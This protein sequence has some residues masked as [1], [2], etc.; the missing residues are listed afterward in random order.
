MHQ[1]L[2]SQSFK[3]HRRPTLEARHHPLETV[4]QERRKSSPNVSRRCSLMPRSRMD[5]PRTD[6]WPERKMTS[7][8]EERF[9]KLPDS[10]DYTRVRQFKIDEKG[11][12]V[13]RGDSFRRKRMHNKVSESS[14]PSCALSPNETDSPREE[15]QSRSTSL[16]S[17]N[18]SVKEQHEPPSTS[19]GSYKIYVL[20]ATGTGKSALIS[21]FITSEYRNPF[22]TEV[23]EQ[24]SSIA[25]FRQ[26][27][28]P[29]S[30]FTDTVQAKFGYQEDSFE[31]TVS[32]NIGGQESEL[33]FY[34]ADPQNDDSWIDREVHIYLLL[35]SID[36]RSSFKQA[37]YVVERLRES[38]STRHMP[39]VM[40]GNK[41]DLERKRAVSKTDAKNMA[42]TFG[43]VHYEISVALNHDV[44]DLLVGL[45]AEIKESINPE[46]YHA[47]IEDEEVTDTDKSKAQD[48]SDFKAAIRRFSQRKK[49]QMGVEVEVDT[50]KCTHFK[51]SSLIGRF[52]N[53][54]ISLP[55]FTY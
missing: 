6:V 39:I 12:V 29:L 19:H 28:T 10:E 44:D 30:N 48:H 41:V 11:A 35:Y 20:G 22:A 15:Y 54:R 17:N 32:V 27:Q 4:S 43:F 45:I 16:S 1:P 14:S 18:D 13:S 3:Q 21:Q 46:R 38:V 24:L 26:L 8:A 55:K 49:K 31:N 42:L 34:E 7:G 33:T 47:D 36:S 25:T 53:W 37:M 23:G 40:A 50:N 9:L 52:R 2:R 5:T 51:P